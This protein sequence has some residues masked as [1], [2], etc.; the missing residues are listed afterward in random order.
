MRWEKKDKYGGGFRLI[1]WVFAKTRDKGTMKVGGES[2]EE[3]IRYRENKGR[4]KK[5]RRGKEKN[6]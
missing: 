2:S 6:I 3:K 4:P 1:N 5:C